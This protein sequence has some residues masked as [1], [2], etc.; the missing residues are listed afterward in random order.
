MLLLLPL[1]FNTVFNKGKILEASSLWKLSEGLSLPPAGTCTPP[2]AAPPAPSAPFLLGQ[3][4]PWWEVLG[5]PC[6]TGVWSVQGNASGSE[7]I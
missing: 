7:E 1:T 3:H 2:T 4:G 5:G 6:R